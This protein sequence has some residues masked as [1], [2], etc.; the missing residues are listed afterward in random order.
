MMLIKRH[1]TSSE[2]KTKIKLLSLIIIG[3]SK[4]RKGVNISLRYFDPGVKISWGSNIV[5]HLPQCIR[6]KC[7]FHVRSCVA[8]SK[9]LWHVPLR[10]MN[11]IKR[12]SIYVLSTTISTQYV[13]FGVPL[14]ETSERF[15]MVDDPT[16]ANYERNM[17]PCSRQIL[18][19]K[20]MGPSI[21]HCKL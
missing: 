2:Y 15:C 16:K 6:V 11:E 12:N 1:T 8:I 5:S 10:R 20:Y 7:L 14:S 17:K 18:S 13:K 21:Y 3:G 4:Y 19:L 9:Y